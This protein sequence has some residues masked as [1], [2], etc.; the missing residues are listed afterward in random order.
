M[1]QLVSGTVKKVTRDSIIVDLGSNAE[2]VLPR[3]ALIPAGHRNRY[4][5][6]HPTVTA[7]YRGFGARLWRTGASG[8]LHVRLGEAAADSPE[9]ERQRTRRYWHIPMAVPPER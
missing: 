9:S 8:A 5:F 7:R 2:A 3:E 6:P 4:G 1:Y